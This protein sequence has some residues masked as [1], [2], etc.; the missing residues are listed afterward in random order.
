MSKS[1]LIAG[2]NQAVNA[3]DLQE[4][5]L[6][7]LHHLKLSAA[8]HETAKGHL[9]QA[10]KDLR[11]YLVVQADKQ[12]TAKQHQQLQKVGKKTR[13]KQ[14]NIWSLAEELYRHIPEHVKASSS[15]ACSCCIALSTSVTLLAL[16]TN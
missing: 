10:V 11:H 8:A 9:Y 14:L 7:I 12:Q 6:S 3:A 1:L 5:L 13:R 4:A 2:Q 15:G 16:N